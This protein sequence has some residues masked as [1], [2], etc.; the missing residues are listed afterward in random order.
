MDCLQW[1]MYFLE[2]Q[3]KQVIFSPQLMEL[4]LYPYLMAERLPQSYFL[5]ACVTMVV[6]VK[7]TWEIMNVEWSTRKKMFRIFHFLEDLEDNW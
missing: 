2:S 6:C 5:L 7:V 1:M 3:S 4:K